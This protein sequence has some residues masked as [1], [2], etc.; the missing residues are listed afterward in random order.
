MKR[1]ILIPILLC[2]LLCGCAAPAVDTDC[3]TVT[4]ELPAAEAHCGTLSLTLPPDA[5][6]A[7]SSEDGQ[8]ALYEAADGSWQLMTAVYRD[9]DPET[10]LRLETGFTSEALHPVRSSRSGL[11]CDTYGWTGSAETGR[12]VCAGTLLSDGAH[13]YCLQFRCA[14]QD[15]KQLQELCRRTLESFTVSPP[16]ET[17][18]SP[19]SP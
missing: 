9:T 17:A 13:C 4:D 15:A 6:C 5:L 18:H 16:Q 8:T 3:F 7:A 1:R 11:T 12:A 2:L 10:A 19:S 14:E